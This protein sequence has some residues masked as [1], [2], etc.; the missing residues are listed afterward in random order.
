ML[1]IFT[2]GTPTVKVSNFCNATPC[3]LLPLHQIMRRE[4]AE[5]FK[6][7]YYRRGKLKSHI[8]RL[9]L[10]LNKNMLGI[11][12]LQRCI[13]HFFQNGTVL[14]QKTRKGLHIR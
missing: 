11:I 12:Y 1:H 2:I 7:N 3:I 8:C 9:F 5:E 6:L 14:Y 13:S 4:V 10:L